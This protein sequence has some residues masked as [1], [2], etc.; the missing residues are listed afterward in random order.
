MCHEL[1]DDDADRCGKLRNH[2]HAEL[3]QPQRLPQAEGAQKNFH[4]P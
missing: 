3:Q 2:R 4:I 1:G